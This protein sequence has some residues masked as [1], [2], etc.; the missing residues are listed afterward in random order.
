MALTFSTARR[1]RPR[2]SDR[3]VVLLALLLVLA[4]G[5]IALMAAADVWRIARQR[6]REVQLLFVGD[7]YRRAIQRYYYGGAAGGGRM[8]P[9]SLEALLDDE[10]SPVPMHH[11]RR[12]YPDP[13][14][15][16]S[17]WGLLRTGDRISGVYSLSEAEPLKK[18][19]FP[20]PYEFFVDQTSYQGWVFAFVGPR[21]SGIV[22]PTGPVAPPGTPTPTSPTS[23]RGNPS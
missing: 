10:R 6:Q 8:L 19:G 3:G 5:G 2:R 11:L 12:L 17:E 16:S 22:A 13:I 23:P 4:L 7:Q 15:G 21:R 9:E 14:T 18:A 1:R 20:K